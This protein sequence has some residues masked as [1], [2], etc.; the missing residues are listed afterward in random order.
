MSQLKC[1][2]ACHAPSPLSVTQLHTHV[3]DVLI[4]SSDL[5]RMVQFSMAAAFE[6]KDPGA[7]V[8]VLG[9]I[10]VRD[11]ERGTLLLQ[12]EHSDYLEYTLA[13]GSPL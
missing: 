8:R 1:D 5:Q 13:L 9:M 4:F 10:V 12:W 2:S 11:R 6:S 7:P 3:D